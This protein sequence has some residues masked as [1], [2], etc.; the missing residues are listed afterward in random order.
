VQQAFLLDG[1]EDVEVTVT[2]LISFD[3]TPLASAVISV[4]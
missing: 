2:K 1:D 4:K 3:D